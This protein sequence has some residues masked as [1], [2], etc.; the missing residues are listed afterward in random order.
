VLLPTANASGFT[1]FSIND[2]HSDNCGRSRW[3]FF[4]YSGMGRFDTGEVNSGE[5]T[6]KSETSSN[7]ST[8]SRAFSFFSSLG[9]FVGIVQQYCLMIGL[10]SVLG[11]SVQGAIST[12]QAFKRA[13]PPS[14]CFNQ[15]K[16]SP[17][18]Q[19]QKL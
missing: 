17:I 16:G 1:P 15:R 18:L 3:V 5:L 2:T 19:T 11:E 9:S 8:T 12:R 6:S 10:Y 13:H 14:K 7:I 4:K